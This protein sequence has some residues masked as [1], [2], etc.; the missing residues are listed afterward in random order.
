MVVERKK[1]ED[2]KF[3]LKQEKAEFESLVKSS[4]HHSFWEEK[5]SLY[6]GKKL[7]DQEKARFEQEK[8]D[9]IKE[10]CGWRNQAL[11]RF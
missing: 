7:L 3:Q 2:E 11:R 5:R 4:P 9:L 10:L 6:N 1:L 8:K